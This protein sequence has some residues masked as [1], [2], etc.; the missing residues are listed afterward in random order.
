MVVANVASSMESLEGST[1]SVV[2]AEGKAAR[3]FVR[4]M[5]GTA[6]LVE[7]ATCGGSV[8]QSKR[9]GES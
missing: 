1:V 5:D 9:Y 3:H 4:D 7:K 6:E 2:N 8:E